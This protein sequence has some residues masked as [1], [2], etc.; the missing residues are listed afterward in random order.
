MKPITGKSF[1]PAVFIKKLLEAVVKRADHRALSRHIIELN[2]KKTILEIISQSACCLKEII[3]YRLFAFAIKTQTQTTAWVDPEIYKDSLEKII[4]KDFNLSDKKDLNLNLIHNAAHINPKILQT[5]HTISYDLHLDDFY[6]KL[7]MIPGKT[8]RLYHDE[9]AKLVLKSATVALSRQIKIQNLSNAA[10]IDP[11]T[12][13]YNRREFENQL[14][15]MIAGAI[16]HRVALSVFIFDLDHFKTINDAYGHPAGDAVLKN[17][18]SLIRNN[19]RE[20]DILARY[21]GEE[22]IA[23]LPRTDRDK[24]IELAERLR[25]K[26]QEYCIPYLDIKIKVCASF[27]VAQFNPKSDGIQTLVKTAD[28]MLYKAKLAG[29]NMV[30]PGLMKIISSQDSNVLHPP[31]KK[32]S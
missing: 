29:R 27:G 16:R 24:A 6:A 18:A 13:C 31:V 22:F 7:Y 23:I 2:H 21:G 5:N 10:T 1:I 20:G 32:G 12:G 17:I 14:K 15:K 28:D 3:Q 11:L 19:M 8:L 4:C 25:I 26:I 9:I 30:M